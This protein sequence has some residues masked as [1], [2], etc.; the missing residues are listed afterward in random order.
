MSWS[1][2]QD[3]LVAS[4]LRRSRCWIEYRNM[5]GSQSL[6]CVDEAMSENSQ[7]RQSKPMREATPRPEQATHKVI[8]NFMIKMT[9]LL[10]T[11][12]ATRR[13]ER[14]PATGADEALERFLKFRPP[15]FYGDVEQET[16]AELVTFAAFRL[17]GMR[18]HLRTNI[19]PGT[20]FKKNSKR[21][22]Y[23]VGFG[24]LTVAQYTAKF[25]RLAKYCLRLI[26]TDE[27]KTRQFMKA[28]RVE[29]QRALAPLPPMGFAAAVEAATR[30]EMADQEV[31]QRKTAFG[32]ATTP[33][34]H[35]G[36]GPWK[37]RDFK[38][39]RGE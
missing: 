6:N 8:E 31:I 22:T 17:R 18:G 35:P 11:S 5:S 30:T 28:L 26:D 21:S 38:R 3:I 37:P 14:V 24:N 33:Y 20:I 29:L 34:K 16:K 12:M 1:P 32:S 39:S 2:N 27:N 13:N 10:E 4:V 9:E 36:Q 23:L 19:G 15:E 25:N 7:N